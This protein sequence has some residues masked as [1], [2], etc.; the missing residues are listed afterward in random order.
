MCAL[1]KTIS[2]FLS[3]TVSQNTL[4]YDRVAAEEVSELGSAY[5]VDG[6]NDYGVVHR[7]ARFDV[8]DF[9][10]NGGYRSA[11]VLRR[12]SIVVRCEW[13]GTTTTHPQSAHRATQ[14]EH[15]HVA[16]AI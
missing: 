5:F 14:T 11:Y 1:Q 4:R 9:A 10:L 7:G 12:N 8:L 13:F 6:G 16:A 15:R 3:V 2:L